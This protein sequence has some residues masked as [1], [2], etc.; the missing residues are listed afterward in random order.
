MSPTSIGH[1]RYNLRRI[2]VMC[3]SQIASAICYTYEI[4]WFFYTK[5]PSQKVLSLHFLKTNK[6]FDLNIKIIMFIGLIA[7]TNLSLSAQTK[8]EELFPVETEDTFEKEYQK[9]IKQDY[10]YGVYIPKD[11]TDAFVQL[12]RLIDKESQAKF[13]SLP[14]AIAVEKLHFSFG[15]WMIYNWSFYE[16][17]RLSVYLKNLGI[18]NPDDMAIFIMLSYHRNLN[19]KSLDVKTQIEQIQAKRKKERE[20]RLQQG[21]ILHEEKRKRQN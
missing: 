13:K 11:L 2:N 4:K 10:I 20:G 12:N 21:Q 14:E 5:I 6:L 17:S 3:L 7:A 19:R 15:R 1:R 8:P 18:Y 9:R 16:G